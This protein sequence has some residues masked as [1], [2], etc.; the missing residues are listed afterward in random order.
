MT[1]PVLANSSL[2][3]AD[4]FENPMLREYLANVRNW[5]GYIR[6]LG[7]PDRRDNPD[8]L[9][10]RL[11]VEPLLTRRHVSP[12]ENPS[13]WI[14][15]A[16]TVFDV[17][18]P[19]KPVVLLGDP[20]T[21]KSTLVNY[22]V[23]LLA[24]PDQQIW[25]KRMGAWLLPIPIVLRELRL[26]EAKDFEGLL[27]AFL[28]HIMCKPL[29]DG[30]Y[31]HQVLADGKAFI[32]FDGID[33]IG[34]L[35]VRKSLRD[36]VFDGFN[37]YPDCRWLL[38]SRIVGYDEVPFDTELE[39]ADAITG[40]DELPHAEFRMKPLRPNE[41]EKLAPQELRKVV[42]KARGIGG[43]R[44][45]TRYIAPFD[46]QRI[47]VFAR[48]WYIQREAAATRAGED[49]L[50]LVRAVHADD[51]ILRLARTP[52]LLIMMALIHRVEATL[53]H[54]RALLY[55]RIAEAYLES[56]DKFR[57]VYSGAYN[58]PQKKR[59]L[60]RV[61]YEMQRRRKSKGDNGE[62]ELLVKSSEVTSWLA[63]EMKR[64]GTSEG[65]STPG[66]VS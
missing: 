26:R 12:D 20:G 44:V 11:F 30:K 42:G 40:P 48:N 2:K 3:M 18:G 63:E 6:F 4:L 35:A 33:E 9:I 55:D 58:L 31:L 51:A 53:P 8:I 43:S 66:R 24:R 54:G 37:R 39:T 41:K 56:I 16:E 50:H 7:L 17:L 15:E 61:G 22:L 46:D 57:G 65:L 52:N 14:D 21:G 13:N 10:D 32:L 34:N 23:W 59:W 60:A 27:D 36:A 5:H 38:S 25:N 62:S 19:G 28:N 64:G 1:N 45:V 49:A 47:E 29:R